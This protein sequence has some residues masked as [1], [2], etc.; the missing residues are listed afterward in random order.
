MLK[1]QPAPTFKATAQIPVAGGD[2]V[3]LEIEYRYMKRRELIDFY[4]RLPELNDDE[5]LLGEVVV[6]WNGYEDSYSAAALK[7]LLDA[8]PRAGKAIYDTFNQEVTG[9]ARKN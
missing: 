4:A 8:Y 1:K 7:D 6:G 9:A 2:S 3:P 5:A